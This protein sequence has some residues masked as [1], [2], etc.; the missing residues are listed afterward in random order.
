MWRPWG[1]SWEGAETPPRTC[2]QNILTTGM[3]QAW[4][5]TGPELDWGYGKPLLGQELTLELLSEFQERN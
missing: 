3:A 5:N 4:T 2:Y 1:Y